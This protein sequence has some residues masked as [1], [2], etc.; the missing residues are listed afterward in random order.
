MFLKCT[1]TWTLYQKAVN[2]CCIKMLGVIQQIRGQNF[3]IVWPPPPCVDSF[4]TLSVDKNRHFDPLP[5]HLVHVVI[6]CPHTR[7]YLSANDANAIVFID[8]FIGNLATQEYVHSTNYRCWN[9]KSTHLIKSKST[10]LWLWIKISHFFKLPISCN[11]RT[12]IRIWGDGFF[13]L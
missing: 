9:L 7:S 11:K 4:Y 3:A 12:K 2:I 1:S 10:L 6:E 8:A 13:T 5:P